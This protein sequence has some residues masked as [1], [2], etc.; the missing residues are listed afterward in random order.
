MCSTSKANTNHWL[1]FNYSLICFS[2]SVIAARN[3]KIIFQR[4]PELHSLL[5]FLF[6]D[7][8]AP[9]VGWR[10]KLPVLLCLAPDCSVHAH[11]LQSG[12]F[13]CPGFGHSWEASLWDSL[14]HGHPSPQGLL[15]PVPH[16]CPGGAVSRGKRRNSGFSRI[17]GKGWG[18]LTTGELYPDLGW[19][20]ENGTF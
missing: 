20:Q 16:C 10:K 8:T 14:R 3:Q 18:D 2:G 13:L 5:F 9:A 17:L 1:H 11:P 15:L 4:N 7:V 19:R 6:E 12:Q